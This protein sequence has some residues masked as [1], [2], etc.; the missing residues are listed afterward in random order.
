MLARPI[1][2]GF[3]SDRAHLENFGSKSDRKCID[4]IPKVSPWPR[5]MKKT[6]ECNIR[7]DSK[8][9]FERFISDFFTTMIDLPFSIFMLSYVSFYV[10]SWVIFSSVY[11]VDAKA[12]GDIDYYQAREKLD[13]IAQPYLN[14]TEMIR[15]IRHFS[16]GKGFLMFFREP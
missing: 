4:L 13:R 7:Q 6:G 9:K 8:E 14:D 1:P 12:R 11:Y 10:F 3:R 15:Q 16:Q 5:F 2:I